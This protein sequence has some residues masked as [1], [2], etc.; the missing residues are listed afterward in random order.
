MTRAR[1]ATRG[2]VAVTLAAL[3]AMPATLAPAAPA[4][5]ATEGFRDVTGSHAFYREISWLVGAGVTTGYA[6]NSFRPA[7]PVTREA[8]AA[9]LY[10]LA[11]R[12]AVTLPARSPF[13]DVP[14]SAPFYREIVWLSQQRITT[15]WSDNTFR[16]Q[17][18][19]TRAALAAFLYRFEGSPAYSPPSRAAFRD[20]PRGAPFYKE[21]SWLASTRISTGWADGT[22][23]PHLGSTRQAT[24]AFLFRS[25]APPGYRA[26]AYTPPV[27][28]DPDRDVSRMLRDPDS[29]L[30]VVNKQR[31][32]VPAGYVP[33]DLVSVRGVPGGS[34]HRLRREAA[35][36]LAAM[37][38]A[39]AAQGMSFSV[40]S[41]YRSRGYQANLFASYVSRHGVASAETFSARPSHSEHQ[42]GL[43]VDVSSGT[44]RLRGCFGTTAVGRWVAQH[45]HTYGFII[46]YPQGKT[47]V[48]G[49]IYE[50]WHLRYVGVELASYMLR[51]GVTTLE[52]QFGLPRAPDYR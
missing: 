49:Y 37:H 47:H 1:G 32:L 7:T 35:E 29:V 18:T 36:Q 48:T 5:A 13:K 26:P 34:G 12:P 21:I 31:P 30:V 45:G 19:I 42:T 20:V 17:R 25:Q 52:E 16:P 33:P 15:G 41:S 27:T 14:R 9:F 23:R 46:R 40:A 8:F 39:A 10:R 11:G 51:Q 22:F 2:W 6:D 28:W 50:P 4:S 43:A 44:C 3:L 24:A 38:R